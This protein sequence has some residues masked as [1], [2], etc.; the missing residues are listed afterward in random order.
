MTNVC[1][2]CFAPMK[3]GQLATVVVT[4]TYHMLK[5][6]ISYA[7]DKSDMVADPDTLIHGDEKDCRYE[8]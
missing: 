5:S 7:L 3:E 8:D 1:R 4:A 2:R 6:Q